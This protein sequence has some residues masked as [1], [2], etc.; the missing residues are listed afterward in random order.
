MVQ[1]VD[2]EVDLPFVF[3]LLLIIKEDNSLQRIE[4]MGCSRGVNAK[5]RWEGGCLRTPNKD[6]I[7]FKKKKWGTVIY[8]NNTGHR[9]PIPPCGSHVMYVLMYLMNSASP[10]I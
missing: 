6:A 7:F 2:I 10:E 5:R 1:R 3:F 4:Q 9:I 8:D